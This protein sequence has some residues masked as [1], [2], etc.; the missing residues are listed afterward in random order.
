MKEENKVP[1]R[2]AENMFEWN[3]FN[4]K[5]EEPQRK[6]REKEEESRKITRLSYFLKELMKKHEPKT[7]NINE[8]FDRPYFSSRGGTK[9]RYGE[10]LR[11][12]NS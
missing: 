11:Y 2:S 5:L 9:Y 1:L 4:R 3:L 12:F 10:L 6:R 7:F 8:K